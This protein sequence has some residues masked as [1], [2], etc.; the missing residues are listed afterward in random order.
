MENSK[1][2]GNKT[3]NTWRL[4]SIIGDL[5]GL[6]GI[7]AMINILYRKFVLNNLD[8]LEKDFGY[9]VLLVVLI[10]ITFVDFI[11]KCIRNKNKRFKNTKLDLENADITNIYEDLKE[12]VSKDLKTEQIKTNILISLKQILLY[13]AVF[14][15]GYLI[16]LF[17]QKGTFESH[18]ILSMLGMIVSFIALICSWISLADVRDR[19][20]QVYTKKY[21]ETIV[22][23]ILKR[24]DNNLK[25]VFDIDELDGEINSKIVKQKFDESGLAT[26]PFNKFFVDDVILNDV[27]GFKIYEID[28]TKM[29][30][31]NG[32]PTYSSFFKGLFL[33]MDSNKNVESKVKIGSNGIKNYSHDFTVNVP[34]ETFNKDF[35]VMSENDTLAKEIVNDDFT[36]KLADLYEKYDIPFELSFK[37]NKMYA[38]LLTGEMFEPRLSGNTVN[39]G[40]I[41]NCYYA[42]E[43][44]KELKELVK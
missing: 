28:V 5:A 23:P 33:E 17:N 22:L 37:G 11:K 8:I 38:R 36:Q 18:A 4:I 44:I 35:Y 9:L 31:L 24:I 27:D 39:K 10:L 40:S 14:G 25:F 15:F 2:N 30:K 21:R 1:M 7:G 32:T 16:V 41:A 12:Q 26:E 3:L 29:R 19:K 42:L 13:T 43:L 6:F 34:N 20:V